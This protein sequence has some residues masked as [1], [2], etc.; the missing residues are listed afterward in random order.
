MRAVG[1]QKYQDSRV[2][3]EKRSSSKC[4]DAVVQPVVEDPVEDDRIP[5]E[6]RSRHDSC[7]FRDCENEARADT[8]P[9]PTMA[10]IM[11]QRQK[12][13]LNHT[14]ELT[15]SPKTANFPVFSVTTLF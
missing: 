12:R 1:L 7:T 8:H 15:V 2:E 3:L 4:N 5:A 13:G 14:S 6:S 9:I 10:H 11:R